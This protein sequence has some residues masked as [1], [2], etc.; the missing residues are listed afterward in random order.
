MSNE[1]K[2]REAFEARM[3]YNGKWPNAIAKCRNGSYLLAHTENAWTEWLACAEA[4]AQPAD[5]TQAAA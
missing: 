5:G 1:Q 2:L 3:T 4:L